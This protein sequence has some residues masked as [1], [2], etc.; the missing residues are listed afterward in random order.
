MLLLWIAFLLSSLLWAQEE[1]DFLLTMKADTLYG[2]IKLDGRSNTIV[3]QYKGDKIPFHASTFEHF[4]IYQK[5]KYRTYKTIQNSVKEEII[6]EV[7]TEGTLNLYR[8]D[9][10]GDKRYG[11][12]DNFRYFICEGDKIKMRVTPKSYKT[13]LKLCI[14]TQPY[15]L[16]QQIVYEDVPRIIEEYNDLTSL[17]S[18]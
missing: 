15:L 18:K 9:T 2:K 14:K 4:G 13:I 11:K 5:G 8:Y 12:G 10:T 7:L 3:F 16:A 1:K 17:N 6:V